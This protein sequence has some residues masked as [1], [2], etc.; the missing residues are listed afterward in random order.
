MDPEGK[1]GWARG[2]DPHPPPPLKN[3]KNIDLLSNT[4]PDAL[5]THKATQPVFNVELHVSWTR[6]RADDGPR[7]VVFW[8]RSSLH[9]IFFVRIGLPLA[10]L[11]GSAH[12]P[13]AMNSLTRT[14][15]FV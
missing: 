1:G 8:I 11:S 3:R 13:V 10:N 12:V 7:L 15:Y 2:P 6:R 5:K 14:T 4:G 9:H